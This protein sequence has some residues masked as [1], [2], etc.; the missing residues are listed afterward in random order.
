MSNRTA[1]T[2]YALVTLGAQAYPDDAQMVRAA[3]ELA[4]LKAVA[5]AADR[6]QAAGGAWDREGKLR[7]L[8]ALAKLD[9]ASG[10]S[11]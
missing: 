9:R 7:L 3:K 2:L 8:R 11:K 4:A 6:L 1:P 5:R 10:G